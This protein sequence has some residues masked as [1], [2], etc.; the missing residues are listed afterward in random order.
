[1]LLV[2]FSF[3]V[4][5]GFTYISFLVKRY[6]KG[7][8]LIVNKMGQVRG[9]IQR[10]SKLKLFCEDFKEPELCSR[11]KE[12]ELFVNSTLEF[13]KDF[14]L[15]NPEFSDIKK[16]VKVMDTFYELEK[17]WKILQ[18]LKDKKKLVKESENAWH[19]AD[20][21][22][23]KAQKISEIKEEKLSFVID[24]I[25]NVILLFVIFLILT[26]YFLITK[27]RG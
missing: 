14:Y 8:T 1:M 6:Y 23:G 15:K 25:R 26:V 19:I 11:L 10:Y 22:T 2:S 17:K 7:D 12:V 16:E 18:N 4:L 9:S 5:A 3:I 13:I 24:S 27:G 20:V 21:L